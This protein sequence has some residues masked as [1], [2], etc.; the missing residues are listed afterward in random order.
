M[1]ASN[2]N[3]RCR[4]LAA[5][6]SVTLLAVA[7]AG[8]GSKPKDVVTECAYPDA[9]DTSAP[10]W[11]CDAPV[12]GVAVGAM[13][14]HEKSAA[15]VAFARDQA[16]A[17]ARFRLAQNMRTYVTGMVKQFAETTGAVGQETVDRTNTS[18]TK[19]V[20]DE[21]ISGSKVFRSATSPKGTFYVYVGMDETVA[22]AAAVKALKTSMANDQ[23]LWQQWRAEK[24]QDELAAAIAKSR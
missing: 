15:G 24:S 18:V 17:S 11:I 14:S 13:G 1:F 4:D 23:A 9:P 2:P 16:V 21:T 10:L 19:Q 20:T 7:L 5:L 12:E 3:T 6:G 8:C 22:K